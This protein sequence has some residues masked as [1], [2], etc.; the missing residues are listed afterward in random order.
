MTILLFGITRDIVGQSSISMP[1]S[2][3]SSLK[4]VGD[5]KLHLQNRY[6]ALEQLSSLVIAVNSTYAGEAEPINSYD[7]IAL[8][9]P[10]SGG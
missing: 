1:D 8:I 10:V 5:L 3:A 4:T 7:E 6:P 9:P 2:Q